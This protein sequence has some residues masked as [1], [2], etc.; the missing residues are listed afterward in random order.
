M[1]VL[2]VDDN[3][4]SAVGMGHVLELWGHDA[5]LVHDGPSAVA[6]AR[7]FLPAVVL[8][9]LGLPGMDGYEVA[10][11]LRRHEALS[12]ALLIALTGYGHLEDRRRAHE[13]GFDL[14]CTK[15]VDLAG[16]RQ[17]LAALQPRT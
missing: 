13:A 14:H 9:D 8:L 10:R 16:L 17:V 6:A 5:C 1:R 4:D 3:V 2:I 12:G 15:P 7:E 11:A